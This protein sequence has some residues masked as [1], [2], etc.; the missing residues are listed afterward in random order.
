MASIACFIDRGKAD[1]ILAGRAGDSRRTYP[2]ELPGDS[3]VTLVGISFEEKS[4]R[5]IDIELGQ[6]AFV[7]RQ[8]RYWFDVGPSQLLGRI[9]H[10]S[11]DARYSW[12]NQAV[13]VLSGEVRPQG[14]DRFDVV[15][16][17]S[18]LV[19]EPMQVT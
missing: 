2:I 19:W 3:A 15:L 8:T 12:L 1:E 16:E 10:L 13:C 17:V 6:A 11:D 9:T 18:E 7:Q 5:L 4:N 14:P